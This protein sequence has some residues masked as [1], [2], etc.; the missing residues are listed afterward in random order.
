MSKEEDMFREW[1]VEAFEF[2]LI[3]EVVEQPE[4]FELIEK[5]AVYVEKVM[6]T[7]T[8]LDRRHLCSSHGYTPDFL[9]RLA[10]L[11]MHML[12]PVFKNTYLM[13]TASRKCGFRLNSKV[14]IDTKGSF[15]N[16]GATQE[17]SINQKLMCHIYGIWPEKVVPWITK[18]DC[19]FKQ[20]WCPES[21]RWKG[22]NRKTPTLTVAGET[23]RTV[24]EFIN[25]GGN[26]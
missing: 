26:G 25:G 22:G 9:I 6:K 8:K 24:R 4:K 2:G 15:M 20:T 10:D 16:R 13:R 23:C 1:A 19:F 7:K 12:L 18:N 17:F 5:Q 21:R 11:G 3:S 14:Y